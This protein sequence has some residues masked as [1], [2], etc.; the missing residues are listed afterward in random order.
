MNKKIS[1][2]LLSLLISSCG[3]YGNL[4]SSNDILGSNL[5]LNSNDNENQA[6]LARSVC[7]AF[8]S[9]RIKAQSASLVDSVDYVVNHSTCVDT[10][11][12]EEK[13]IT[14]AVNIT[15]DG[16]VQLI[17][18]T[19][20]LE[21]SYL[22]TDIMGQ[23]PVICSKIFNNE[24]PAFNEYISA[25]Q[26]KVIKFTSTSSFYA[27]LGVKEGDGHKMIDKVSY[28]INIV[29]SGSA[30]YGM[31]TKRDRVSLCASGASKVFTRSLK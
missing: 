30:T 22:Q 5:S 13:T 2:T 23:L 18:S 21:E 25:T 24:I 3:N 1:I 12:I 17:D 9:K 11:N 14:A 20:T 15:Q 27:A 19:G 4:E 29:D 31:V 28:D 26:V 16:Q 6:S 8:R 7:N 10:E